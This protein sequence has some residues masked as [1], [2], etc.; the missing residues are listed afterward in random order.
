M[1]S[2]LYWVEAPFPGRLAIMARPRGGEWLSDEIAGLRAETVDII[3]SLLE[4]AEVEE[5]G[6]TEEPTQCRAHGMEF[7]SF[8]IP[9]R[10]VPD[11][12]TAAAP[13]FRQLSSAL[14]AGRSVVV[15]C[16]A[17]I[18]RS[19]LVAACIMA[20]SASSCDNAFEAIGRARGLSVP[21][22]DEQRRWF[23]AFETGSHR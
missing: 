16:R 22:T 1:L 14:T 17:G 7:I 2:R 6:L 21:D 3:V 15:H 5:L 23:A 19:S 9:D 8:P 4:P 10:G 18:G 11:S 13:L 12:P 20:C